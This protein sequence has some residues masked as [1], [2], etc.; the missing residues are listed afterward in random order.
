LKIR[1]KLPGSRLTTVEKD[2]P[3]FGKFKKSLLFDNFKKICFL[4]KFSLTLVQKMINP[5]NLPLKPTSVSIFSHQ[6]TQCTQ[7]STR[8]QNQ[9]ETP[10]SPRR[11]AIF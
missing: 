9:P 5:T 8:R 11:K 4:G 1:K 2:L 3:F 10:D 6:R 7:N